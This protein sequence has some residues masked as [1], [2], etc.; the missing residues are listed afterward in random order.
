MGPRA[1]PGPSLG[2][3]HLLVADCRVGVGSWPSVWL[4]MAAAHPQ[5]PGRCSLEGVEAGPSP[6][7][8]TLQLWGNVSP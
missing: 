8:T 5:R 7:A 2:C 4:V 3:S 1:V 6:D